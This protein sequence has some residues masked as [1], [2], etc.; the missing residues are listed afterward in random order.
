MSELDCGE[1]TAP[2]GWVFR[3]DLLSQPQDITVLNGVGVCQYIISGK[4]ERKTLETQLAEF[5]REHAGR[6]LTLFELEA[7]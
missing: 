3:W 4:I 7:L 1:C 6:Q 5:R 2:D